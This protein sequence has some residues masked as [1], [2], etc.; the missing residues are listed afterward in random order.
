MKITV[1]YISNV[2]LAFIFA[3]LPYTALIKMFIK[4]NATPFFTFNMVLMVVLKIVVYILAVTGLEIAENKAKE[5][6][7]KTHLASALFILLVLPVILKYIIGMMI[8][9]APKLVHYNI[10]MAD[11]IILIVYVIILLIVFFRYSEKAVY[12]LAPLLIYHIYSAFQYV[13]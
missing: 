10:T 13:G 1:N 2:F 12:F 7:V 9:V 6:G 3:L 11:D 5:K 8:S 4:N